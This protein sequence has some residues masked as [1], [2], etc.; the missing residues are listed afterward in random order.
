MNTKRRSTRD[1]PTNAWHYTTGDCW[2]QIRADGFLKCATAFVRE[3]VRPCVWF[4][5]ADI[6]FEPMA[7]KAVMSSCGRYLVSLSARETEWMGNGLVRVGVASA[8]V[9]STWRDYRRM[10]GDTSAMLRAAQD[11]ARK[12]G[13]DF[14]KWRIS[15]QPVPHM[16]WIDA[17][18]LDAAGWRSLKDGEEPRRRSSTPEPMMNWSAS[19]PRVKPISKVLDHVG[20]LAFRDDVMSPKRPVR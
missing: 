4:T 15:W 2:L 20:D 8:D 11:V 18:V 12:K 14:H 10:S 6:E 3:G 7:T 17:Q 1:E 16:K 9:P 13:S 19:D 5:T